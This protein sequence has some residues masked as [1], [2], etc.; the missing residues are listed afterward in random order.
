M[1]YNSKQLSKQRYKLQLIITMFDFFNLTHN[2]YFLFT[3]LIIGSHL[4]LFSTIGIIYC[5]L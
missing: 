3:I 1:P 5:S 4:E 2:A